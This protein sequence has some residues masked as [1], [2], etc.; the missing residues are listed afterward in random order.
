MPA[1]PAF[2]DECVDLELVE[3]LRSRGYALSSAQLSGLRGR[4]DDELLA[5]AAQRDLVLITH[6]ERHF[7][8]EHR[9]MLEAGGSHGGIVCL[10][11][12]GPSERLTLRAAMMLEWL[13][14][15]ESRSGFFVWGRLQQEI[16]R[17]LR[18][19]GFDE[20]DLEYALARD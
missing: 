12:T 19:P 6:N 4:P 17:G 8:R 13:G 20:A 11:Q 9:Q 7:R 10:P 14:T 15:Q 16:E 3:A 1:P 2:L 5:Y 18:L